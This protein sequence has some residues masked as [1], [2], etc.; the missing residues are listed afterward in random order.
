MSSPVRLLAALISALALLP[1]TASAATRPFAPTSF[2][3]TP[4]AADAQLDAKSGTYVADLQ[5]Q[6]TQWLPWINT[7]SSS[8][9]VYTVGADQPLVKVALDKSGTD[10]QTVALRQ[11]FAAV[12]VPPDA[13]PAQGVDRNLVVHQPDTDTMWEFWGMQ[14]LADGWHAKWGGKM[15]NVSTSSGRYEYPNNRWGASATSLPLLGGLMRLDELQSG[16]IDHALAISIPQVRKDV[17]S[18]P[19]QRTDG[20]VASEDAIPEGTRFRLPAN[21]NLAAIPMSPIVRQMAIAAQ[22]YGVVVRDVSGSIAFYG[23]DPTP[24]G[25][26]PYAGLTGYFLGKYP[27]TLLAQ[28]P[29]AKLQ[30]LKTT[31]AVD[32]I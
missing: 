17:Y 25:T 8:E 7:T 18:W 22:K 11:A 26:N 24:T 6:L 9:P 2:W 10:S 32:P 28:F 16:V 19:A 31:L 29:W 4:L 12:P 30:A 23:E 14:K 15:A 3:N 1:A 27:S 20:Q 21:L 13:R 5:R